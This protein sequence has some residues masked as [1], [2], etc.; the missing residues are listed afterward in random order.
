MVVFAR[1]ITILLLCL[2]PFTISAQ[3]R[4][5]GSAD[6]PKRTTIVAFGDGFMSGQGVDFYQAFPATLERYLR[7]NGYNR[8]QVFNDSVATDTSEDAL[9]RVEEVLKRNPD[10]VLL[11]F[12]SNDVLQKKSVNSIYHNLLK[13]VTIL[14]ANNIRVFLIGMKAPKGVDPEY[15]KKLNGMYRYLAQKNVLTFYPDFLEGVAGDPRLSGADMRHPNQRGVK[16]IVDNIGPFV[17]KL[18]YSIA[19]NK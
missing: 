16:I 14:K 8:L 11:S 19:Y 4:I 2:L 5:V 9:N 17:E 10:I 18:L 7:R 12:G 6:L 1:F 3:Q 15:A 13:V